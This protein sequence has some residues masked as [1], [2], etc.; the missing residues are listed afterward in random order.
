MPRSTG[1]GHGYAANDV[2]VYTLGDVSADT[3]RI[4]S[5]CRQ[6]RRQSDLLDAADRQAWRYRGHAARL[7]RLEPTLHGRPVELAAR[8]T[9]NFFVRDVTLSGTMTAAKASLPV[10]G[11]YG[12]V[13]FDGLANINVTANPVTLAFVN[14]AG[15]Y[16][17]I[18][19]GDLRTAVA[20]DTI[21]DP[22]TTTVTLGGTATA[23]VDLGAERQPARPDATARGFHG[24][25]LGQGR[26]GHL[27]G[28][29]WPG[30]SVHVPQPR[31]PAVLT[32]LHQVADYLRGL[33]DP[34]LDAE[35]PLVNKSVKDLL[36][37]AGQFDDFVTAI[38]TAPIRTCRRWRR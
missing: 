13:G 23:A 29:P 26:H 1:Y 10:N 31:L 21:A 27:G 22:S 5:R 12:F 8:R 30:R 28:R 17:K 14:P 4:R 16:P 7:R 38:G 19:L 34:R 32:A 20:E 2:L 3:S 25:Q 15:N 9:D 24:G 37:Y 18:K 33:N 6:V 11:T 35:L 36:D